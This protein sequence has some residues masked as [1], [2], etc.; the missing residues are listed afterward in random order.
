MKFG[1][2]DHMDDSGVPQAAFFEPADGPEGTL[3]RTGMNRR[4]Q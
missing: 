1:I 4:D 3:H 2:F